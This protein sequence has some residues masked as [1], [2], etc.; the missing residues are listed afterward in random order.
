MKTKQYLIY[1]AFITFFLTSCVTNYYQVYKVAP[2]E[3]MI[4]TDN[5]LIFE[6]DN[7]KISYNLWGEGGNCGFYIYNKTDEN[8]Y[9]DLKQSFFILNGFAYDYFKSRV[10]THTRS[11]SLIVSEKAKASKATTEISQMGKIQTNEIQTSIS[12]GSMS[13]SG[14]STSY[15]EFDIICVPSKT[16]K[17]ISEYKINNSLYR[18]CDLFRYPPKGLVETKAFSK[19][20]SPLIFSNRIT[21][22]IGKSEKQYEFENEFYVSEISNY[23]ESDIIEWRFIEFCG[24]KS[25]NKASF[26]KNSSPDKFYIKYTKEVG[27]WLH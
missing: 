13:S 25:K 12:V 7:C 1:F 9:L 14:N 5:Y 10:Y 18:D 16:S 27:S 23:H 8:L 24:Q 6:D 11:S 20:D 19:S 2:T 3:K 22:T 17:M 26:F 21:Y 4:K 15:D